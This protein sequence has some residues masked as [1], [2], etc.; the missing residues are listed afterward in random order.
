MENIIVCSNAKEK[1][2]GICFKINTKIG[3]V[4]TYIIKA[5]LTEGI[6]AFIYCEDSKKNRLVSSKN[7]LING[8]E[9]EFKFLVKGTDSYI[10]F[11]VLF[12]NATK[13]ELNIKHISIV[14]NGMILNKNDNMNLIKGS[15]IKSIEKHSMTEKKITSGQSIEQYIK[16][17]NIV[18]LYVSTP[19][20]HYKKIIKQLNEYKNTN[21]ATLFIGIYSE[22]DVNVL[23]SHVGKKVIYWPNGNTK[24]K[25]FEKI[26]EKINKMTN[27]I[28][29]SNKTNQQHLSKHGLI[30]ERIY[31]DDRKYA[32]K[33]LYSNKIIIFGENELYNKIVEKFTDYDIIFSNN[34][35]VKYD[36]IYDICCECVMG[37]ILSDS[38]TEND[39]NIIY[40][41]RSLNVLVVCNND[42]EGAMKWR[43]VDDIELLVKYR[44]I[45][46][47]NNEIARYKKILFVCTDYPSWGG[48]ATNTY[49]LI[50]WYNN[51][52]DHKAFGLFLHNEEINKKYENAIIFNTTGTIKFK[53]S[54]LKIKEYFGSSPDLII[55]RNY[56]DLRL[57]RYFDCP[58]YFLIPGIFKQ[59]LTNYSDKLT[60]DEINAFVNRDVLEVINKCDKCFTNSFETKEILKH[61][62]TAKVNILHFNYI[63]FYGNFVD[64]NENEWINRKYAVGII[65]SDF[66]RKIKNINLI[67]RIFS[68]IPNHY[69]IVIGKN[70]N[71]IRGK[72][73][74]RYDLLPH[75]N[76]KGIYSKVK[77]VINTSFY[78]SCSNV[79]IEAKFNGCKIKYLND[80]NYKEI[81][82]LLKVPK[83]KTLLEPDAVESEDDNIN[84]NMNVN[85]NVNIN[86][87]LIP[88]DINETIKIDFFYGTEDVILL[89]STQY[90]H[91]GGAATL[92]YKIHETLIEKGYNSHCLFL[93]DKNECNYNPNNVKNVYLRKL[94][95]DYKDKGKCKLYYKQI[96]NKIKNPSLIIGFNY[97]SPIIGKNLYENSKVYYY[98]TGSRYITK[99]NLSATAYLNSKKRNI[100]ELD[101]DELYCLNVVDYIIP[102]SNLTNN[103][104]QTMFPEFKIKC[105]K[106]LELESLFYQDPIIMTNDKKHDIVVISSRFNRTVKNM[107]LINDIY[108]NKLLKQYNK[109][110][111]GM[112]SANVIKKADIHYGFKSHKETIEILKECRILLIASKY[113]SYSL[114]LLDGIRSGCIVLSNTNVGS[115]KYMNESYIIDSEDS[116]LWV[117]K[118]LTILNNFDY[119][120]KLFNFNFPKID[121]IDSI[122]YLTNYEKKPD[123]KNILF[124]SVDKPY[125]GG[126]STNT[127]NMIKT[128]Q[129][130]DY[131]NPI[132]IF[133]S[134][135]K[136]DIGVNPLNYNNV[137][138]V[139]YNEQIERNLFNTINDI[140]KLLSVD[141]IFV[142]NYKALMC[143][144]WINNKLNEKYKI[145]FSPSGLR[146]IDKNMVGMTKIDS[147]SL[148]EFIKNNDKDLE[149]IIY[150]KCKYIIPNSRLTYEMINNMYELGYNL[151]H[152]CSIT[153]IDYKDITNNSK[154]N[155]RKYD[156]AFICYSWSRKVKNYA[157]VKSLIERKELKDYNILVIGKGQT[158]YSKNVEQIDNCSNEEI[159]NYLLQTKLL[160][161]PSLFDSCPN[162]LKEGLMCGCNIV[163]SK[164]V[165]SYE[166]FSVN[167]LVE[168]LD[169][170]KEWI[171]KIKYNLNNKTKTVD[172][173]PYLIKSQLKNNILSFC[174]EKC[175][176]Q[177]LESEMSKSG[178]GVYKLPP[179][180][181]KNKFDDN[182]SF[183]VVQDNNMNVREIITNDVYYKLFINNDKYDC[184]YYH[185]IT[186]NTNSPTNRYTQPYFTYPY[187]SDK[188]YIWEINS[189]SILKKFM[190]AKYYFLRGNYY[191]AYS[192][193]INKSN[194]SKTILYPATALKYK[195]NLNLSVDKVI[196]HPFDYVLY[197]DIENLDLWQTMFPNSTLVK[198]NKPVSSTIVYL[199][200]TR[201]YD[202]IFVATENQI[203]KNR[204]L[205]VDFVL[206]C[207]KNKKRVNIVNIGKYDHNYSKLKNLKYVNLVSYDKIT[208]DKIIELFNEAKI[209]LMFSGRD[210]LPRVVTESLGCGCFNIAL[211]TMTDGKYLYNDIFGSM[212]SYP[213]LDKI[214]DES[215]KSISYLSNDIIFADILK[216]KDQVF[217]HKLISQ[218]YLGNMTYKLNIN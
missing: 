80:D 199:N 218:T 72:K 195:Y 115:S 77:Y 63:P 15:N 70:N 171:Q 172:F 11:G 68:L 41:L 161:I 175:L 71:L 111:I 203:T 117:S 55:L 81:V 211:D 160:C 54:I 112:D 134:T 106:I 213:N 210:A 118:I 73:I 206:Y 13:Y 37:I 155:K 196:H 174:S 183:N 184:E 136:N 194:N 40:G 30:S 105:T 59:N 45:H 101:V 121:I 205:F 91:Y 27:V 46:M 83:V 124:L 191:D 44:N 202:Y 1:L 146:T 153:F 198:L 165:G 50:N 19:V 216:Y 132:G 61:I 60:N 162:V 212:L 217:D 197:D 120:K 157:L 82:E 102:N 92:A 123:R 42:F 140:E 113:E 95:E 168:D 18:Q 158:K 100:D 200:K 2:S 26:V 48:A 119:H 187:V 74:K 35:K 114:T 85:M 173:Y 209:N 14:S 130:D 47:F 9:K 84:A 57:M 192:Q 148:Y 133:I 36:D 109:V 201:K 38:Y 20:V 75:E 52:S 208:Y 138:H 34:L 51:N 129:N 108:S 122:N 178:V 29:L 163:L 43:D 24:I 17:K 53:K 152:P 181:D 78:E 65:V 58:K 135:D 87:K 93:H 185:Y 6:N 154:Q 97:I 94:Y 145:I 159:L 144:L 137:Y 3:D 16:D 86:V 23:E 5:V 164:N 127:Y 28:N 190:G 139:E 180:W 186:V 150:Y 176:N 49:E 128:Y 141:G 62:S 33:N 79:M 204:H 104:F 99:N 156:I 110:C 39:L 96:C 126:C 169:N 170:I 98:I 188:I 182:D 4:Y 149:K 69:K 177:L 88:D 166:Y 142:K 207:E 143:M 131:I 147:A 107:D 167:N 103:V 31:V 12:P 90:P 67:N 125:N 76:V 25:N 7:V 214:Y 56:I 8:I 193:F 151:K 64:Y 215:S 32:K 179:E 10:N 66:S 89:M 21:D 22:N 116:E 189:S